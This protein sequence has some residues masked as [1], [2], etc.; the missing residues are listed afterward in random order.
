MMPSMADLST[1]SL[2][3]TDLRAGC[4]LISTFPD[5]CAAAHIGKLPGLETESTTEIERRILAGAPW[6]LWGYERGQM[7]FWRNDVLDWWERL[8]TGRALNSGARLSHP[9]EARTGY[10]GG[11]SDYQIHRTHGRRDIK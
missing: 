4:R 3:D 11:P 6:L 5:L 8:C 10:F 9:S 2:F 7:V 1:P